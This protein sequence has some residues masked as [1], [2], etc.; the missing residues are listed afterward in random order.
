MSVRIYMP[1]RQPLRS[2]SSVRGLL[3]KEIVRLEA[4]SYKI[5]TELTKHV[6]LE[7]V[8]TKITLYGTNI[9]VINFILKIMISSSLLVMIIHRRSIHQACQ[10]LLHFLQIKLPMIPNDT[11]DLRDPEKILLAPVRAVLQ[12]PSSM[13]LSS[14]CCAA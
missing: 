3:I 5:E 4:I 9:Y 8:D 13:T 7:G 14:F 10:V 6:G 11:F 2:S 12:E 1:R